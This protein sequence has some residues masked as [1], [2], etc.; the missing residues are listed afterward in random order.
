MITQFKCEAHFNK[1]HVTLYVECGVGRPR[2]EW[3][4]G[5][6]VTYDRII[7]GEYTAPFHD[8][9]TPDKAEKWLHRA[10]GEY[11]NFVETIEWQCRHKVFGNLIAA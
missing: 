10:V 6:C 7:V 4:A 9:N 11:G 2:D 3:D 1:L 8:V 5:I